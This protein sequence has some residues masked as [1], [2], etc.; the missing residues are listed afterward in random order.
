MS[1]D[2]GICRVEKIDF[3]PYNESEVL[4]SAICHYYDRH[5]YYPRRGL[6]DKI[7]RNRMN[8]YYCKKRGIRLSVPSL[9][10]P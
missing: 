7:Y 8:I 2:N 9:G 4:V 10:R 1:M 5:G 3:N 6:A